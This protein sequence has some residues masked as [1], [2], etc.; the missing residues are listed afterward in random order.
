MTDQ[1]L[2]IRVDVGLWSLWVNALT[3]QLS[4]KRAQDL[5]FRFIIRLGIRESKPLDSF[6]IT[7]T[8][9]GFASSVGL[10]ASTAAINPKL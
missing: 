8:A 9:I 10:I 4:E 7:D 2:G 3:K 6:T 5:I 1:Q